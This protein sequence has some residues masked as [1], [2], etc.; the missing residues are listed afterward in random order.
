MRLNQYIA[1]ASGLSRRAADHAITEG[2]VRHNNKL[3]APGII[4]R[5]GDTITLDGKVIRPSSKQ[6]IMLNKPYGYV[7]SRAGQGSK[8]IYDLL[9]KEFHLLNPVGRLD[10]DS[11]GL[12]L[13][14]ND[15]SL[16]HGLT[17][18]SKQKKK[19]YQIELSQP[20]NL[21]DQTDIT[22][23]VD[24]D[25]GI[26]HLQLKGKERKWQVTMTEG[27]NRQIRRTFAARG[28]KVT[29][30]HRSQFG[31]YKLG[32]LAPGQFKQV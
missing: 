16:H 21:N 27:R 10:R 9:P 6:T 32:A 24:L 1:A 13:L 20:L 26:S 29:R 22:I 18:P 19:V 23:G 12:L 25:D 8:T 31:D 3:A 30:L 4:V 28:Y 5:D 14:T 17:H 2:R 7:C 15:G 11:T